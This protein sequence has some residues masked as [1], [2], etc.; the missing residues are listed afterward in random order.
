MGGGLDLRLNG[1]MVA[2]LY[3]RSLVAAGLPAT[4]AMPVDYLGS[5]RR[6]IL[7]LVNNPDHKFLPETHLNFLTK[8]LEACKLDLGDVA[9]I[10][11]ARIGGDT[12][13]AELKPTTVLAFGVRAIESPDIVRANGIVRLDAPS[14][15]D[16][17]SGFPQERTLKAA[18]WNRLQN[19]FPIA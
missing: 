15:T 1:N 13:I 6:G 3:G 5:Y 14:L 11:T 17:T 16:F 18:L 12:A 10:N 9:V 8:L 2:A 7:V 4:S 19:I